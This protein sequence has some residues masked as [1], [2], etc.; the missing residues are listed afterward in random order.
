VSATTTEVR[1]EALAILDRMQTMVDNEMVA[2]VGY[3][4]E[5]VVRPD[6]KEAGAICGGRNA[7]VVGSLWL[8]AGAKPRKVQGEWG[9][10]VELPGV[11]PGKRKGYLSRKP[12]LKLAYR[13]LNDAAQAYVDSD[14]SLV[15]EPECVTEG[16]L[17]GLFE[18]SFRDGRN[19]DPFELTGIIATARAAIEASS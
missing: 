5:Y 9:E 17:E 4:N 6:L 10:I 11:E 12:E 18:N 15:Y 7:C 14:D 13:A 8:A 19:I 3:V 1:V 2:H 16:P